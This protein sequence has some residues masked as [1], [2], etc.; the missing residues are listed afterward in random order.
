MN[1]KQPIPFWRWILWWFL[2]CV[3]IVVFYIL[4]TPFWLAVRAAAWVASRSSR[5]GRRR[6]LA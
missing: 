5:L 3:G 2:L 1:E 6:S 4:M